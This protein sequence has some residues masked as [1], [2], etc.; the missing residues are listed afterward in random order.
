MG[1]QGVKLGL[2]LIG[3]ARSLHIGVVLAAMVA[4]PFVVEG[5]PRIGRIHQAPVA[6]LIGVLVQDLGEW[7]V[8]MAHKLTLCGS[9]FQIDELCDQPGVA[10]REGATDGL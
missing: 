5:D 4:N 10:T 3:V 9:E 2:A 1:D 6:L 8:K 7:I